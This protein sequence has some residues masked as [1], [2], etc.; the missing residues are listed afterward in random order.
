ML[1]TSAVK[2]IV[3]LFTIIVITYLFVEKKSTVL[4]ETAQ[5]YFD[6]Y[7]SLPRPAVRPFPLCYLLRIQFD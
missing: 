5:M 1:Y 7:F 4:R 3:R 2:I 6:F